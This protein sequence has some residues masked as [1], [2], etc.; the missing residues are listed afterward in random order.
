VIVFAPIQFV[1]ERFLV[2][3]PKFLPY[4][5]K[6]IEMLQVIEPFQDV[7]TLHQ[8]EKLQQKITCYSSEPSSM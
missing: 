1:W 2:S 8:T 7:D 6:N 4:D 3:P 5:K